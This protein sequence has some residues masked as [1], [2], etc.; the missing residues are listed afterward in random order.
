MVGMKWSL[1]SKSEISKLQQTLEPEK[2]TINFALDVIT[3]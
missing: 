1:I 3:M 2:H